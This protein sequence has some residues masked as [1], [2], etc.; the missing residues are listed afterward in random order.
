MSLYV[1]VLRVSECSVGS[2]TVLFRYTFEKKVQIITG[3]QDYEQPPS[4]FNVCPVTCGLSIKN[5]TALA[6]SSGV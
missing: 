2:S 1:V 6:I 3:R 4:T 5:N